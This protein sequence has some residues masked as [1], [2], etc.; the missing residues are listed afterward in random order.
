MEDRTKFKYH[1]NV[2]NDDI[3]VYGESKCQ[4][5]EQ[6]VNVYV[7][8][9]YSSEDINCICLKCIYDGTAS[10]KFNCTFVE[11]AESVSDNKKKEELF[12]RTPGYLG[13]QGEYWLACCN[14]YCQY[15][16]RVGID[17][18]KDLGIADEVID[19]YCKRDDSYSKDIV[20]NCMYKDG[21]MSGYLFKCIHCNKHKLWVDAN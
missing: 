14:D 20:M 15:I 10:K 16:G 2:Y 3:V 9:L 4:C 1:P 8:H 7:E 18:L 5:C 6:I 13:W 12:C 17:E 19:E 11:S 21:D